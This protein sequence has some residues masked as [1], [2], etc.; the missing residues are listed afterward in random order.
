MITIT[1][2]GVLTSVLF[3]I[4]VFQRPKRLKK[5]YQ[6]QFRHI[7]DLAVLNAHILYRKS[8]GI[9]SRLNFILKLVDR[10]IK[11]YSQEK[12]QIR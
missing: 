10:V 2:W 12:I 11:T 9:I 8:G 5:Y 1:Q 6:K 4:V 3:F 7:L